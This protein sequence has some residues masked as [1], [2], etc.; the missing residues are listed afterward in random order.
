MHRFGVTRWCKC[1][2][3]YV[4]G[5]R[6]PLK[7]SVS[8]AIT[9]AQLR[10]MWQDAISLPTTFFLALC[11]SSRYRPREHRRGLVAVFVVLNH[12]LMLLYTCEPARNNGRFLTQEAKLNGKRGGEVDWF[13]RDSRRREKRFARSE[14][15]SVFGTSRVWFGPALFSFGG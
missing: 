5:A 10:D 6:S 15:V 2:E 4:V 14:P 1:A 12:I 13:G 7:R 3:T 8:V 9:T 11:L